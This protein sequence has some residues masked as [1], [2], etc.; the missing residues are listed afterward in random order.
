MFQS[1]TYLN[2]KYSSLAL[3]C[4]P[5]AAAAQ[6]HGDEPV[7]DLDPVVVSATRMATP[8]TELG[9]SIS[10]IS[11]AELERSRQ[12]F[13]EDTLRRVPGV[14]VRRNGG[15]GSTTNVSIRGTQTGQSL[16]LIN[17]VKAGDPTSSTP[18]NFSMLSAD[19]IE[20][21]EIIRG[22]QSTIYGADAI[23]G[24]IN[25][26][27]RQPEDGS[28][29]LETDAFAGSYGT[30][31]ASAQ[32]SGREGDWQYDGLVSMFH[33]DGFSART[34]RDAEA[35]AFTNRTARGNLKY[36]GFNQLTLSSFLHY[37]TNRNE[38]DAS[39]PD[40]AESYQD[41]QHWIAGLNGEFLTEDESIESRLSL[42]F[43]ETNRRFYAASD[44]Y[45][46]GQMASTLWENVFILS[47]TLS[48]VS[49]FEYEDNRG[50]AS[51]GIDA[52]IDNKSAFAL[53]RGNPAD[54]LFVD[55][56][57][58]V[59][60]H[61]MFSAEHTWRTTGSYR[62]NDVNTRLKS[63]YGTSFRAPNLYD[64]YHP[65]Y[66]NPNL[67]P[68]KGK[69]FDIGIEQP[70]WNGHI[71][72][73]LTY[74]HNAIRDQIDFDFRGWDPATGVVDGDYRNLSSVRTQGYEFQISAYPLKGLQLTANYTWTDT[75]DRDA[76]TALARQPREVLSLSGDYSMLDNRLSL[77]ANMQYVGERYNSANE[78]NRMP[79]YTVWNGTIRYR[80]SER[81]Q[82]YLRVDNLFDKYYEEIIGYSTPARSAYV[83]LTTRF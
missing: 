3:L 15:P 4:L 42:S 53:L 39:G 25:V 31:K 80:I 46:R 2:L 63:S 8:V 14:F 77:H 70:L 69:G 23:G 61:S 44:S 51:D 64:L 5:G 83:G 57:G 20:R 45:F 32:L 59:D 27:T 56:S 75:L 36:T 21:I 55:I 22:P 30:W 24:V 60:D 28:M 37:D 58:R 79:S 73:E 43:S 68:E 65:L 1:N 72:T 62:L 38:Y 9:N 29:N 48:L 71:L 34:P 50:V 52:S 74:F 76:G 82:A 19:N 40:D 6:S 35:D 11:G 81:F 41:N 18:F 54:R 17:S 7:W 66:G 67:D 47:E 26:I 10:V 12:P 33:T 13:L 16:V 78:S 49:G